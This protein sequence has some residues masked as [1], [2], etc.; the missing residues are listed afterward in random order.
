MEERI[1]DE[2]TPYWDALAVGELRIQRCGACGI[3]R[4]PPTRYCQRCGSAAVD[5]VG[6][7]GS[8]RL[9]SWVVTHRA[10]GPDVVEWLPFTVVAVRLDEQDDLVMTGLLVDAVPEDLVP[11][12][13]MTLEMVRRGG[14]FLIGWRPGPRD[15]VVD[16]SES[17]PSGVGDQ[18]AA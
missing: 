17:P 14:E 8:G 15:R 6:A 10:P 13:A 1:I 12:M 18:G 16:G 5:W 2:S 11:G 4:F 9:Y 7:G 3:Y